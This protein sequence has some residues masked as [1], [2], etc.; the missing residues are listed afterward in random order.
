MK[1]FSIGNKVRLRRNTAA[2]RELDKHSGRRRGKRPFKRERGMRLHQIY[3]LTYLC[4]DVCILTS[5]VE[6]PPLQRQ[7]YEITLNL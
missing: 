2:T 3:F 5:T 4:G 6:D 7:M 1:L